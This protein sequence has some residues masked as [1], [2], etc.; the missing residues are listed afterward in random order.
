[1]I[2]VMKVLDQ[3]SFNIM[4]QFIRSTKK[5][6]IVRNSAEKSPS[7]TD[8]SNKDEAIKALYQKRYNTILYIFYP[9]L[10]Q[11]LILSSQSDF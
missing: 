5:S 6:F 1:M 3:E 7:N 8:N 4:M 9:K 2:I 11:M 10:P